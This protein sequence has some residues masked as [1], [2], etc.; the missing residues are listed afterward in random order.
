MQCSFL[1]FA[2]GFQ[3]KFAQLF[4]L[5]LS[6]YLKWK[7]AR[8]WVFSKYH[9]IVCASL[10]Y[11]SSAPH[12]LHLCRLKKAKKRLLYSRCILFVRGHVCPWK[13]AGFT[14]STGHGHYGAVALT[15]S[16][17]SHEWRFLCGDFLHT[18]FFIIIHIVL[19]FLNLLSHTSFQTE[20]G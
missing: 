12:H 3:R 13:C 8:T 17:G 9:G 7:Q 16:T 6:L 11:F 4:L 15:S 10:L 2:L 19:V 14:A 20:L 1:S 18:P 5:S